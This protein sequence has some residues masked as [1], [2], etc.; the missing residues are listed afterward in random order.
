MILTLNLAVGL[1]V[2]ETLLQAV[3]R[4]LDLQLPGFTPASDR[5]KLPDV[6]ARCVRVAVLI[7]I[8][9]VLAE[10]WVVDVLRLVDAGSGTS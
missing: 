1:L 5:Q 2:F 6:V 8:V 9:V 3:V 10:S 4:R 7:G